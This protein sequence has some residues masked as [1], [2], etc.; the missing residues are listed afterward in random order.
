MSYDAK[1]CEMTM[2]FK[3]YLL[4]IGNFQNEKDA[5]YSLMQLFESWLVSKQ[6]A[7][8]IQTHFI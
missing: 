4:P 6:F 2:E 3:E 7:N 5:Y 8:F 1:V